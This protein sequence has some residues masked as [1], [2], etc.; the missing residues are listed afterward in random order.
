MTAVQVQAAAKA[1]PAE[2]VRRLR[3]AALGRSPQPLIAL[4]LETQAVQPNL[5][6]VVVAHVPD[7]PLSQ[8]GSESVRKVGHND[9]FLAWHN[10]AEFARPE[11]ADSELVLQKCG[12]GIA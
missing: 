11:V 3:Q 2:P 7:A 4:L 6:P 12:D 1:V 5:N 9:C 10:L 8:F